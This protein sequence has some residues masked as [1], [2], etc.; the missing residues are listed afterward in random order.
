MSVD[1]QFIDLLPKHFMGVSE[2][3]AEVM[4]VISYE[5]SRLKTE[6]EGIPN[7]VDI[8]TCPP[9]YLP[10]IAY[11]L[12]VTNFPELS[13]DFEQRRFLRMYIEA[14]H[15]KG[16]IYAIQLLFRGLFDIPDIRVTEMYRHIFN[17]WYNYGNGNDSGTFWDLGDSVKQAQRAEGIQVDDRLIDDIYYPTMILIDLEA[18]A[19]SSLTNLAQLINYARSII[20]EFIPEVCNWELHLTTLTAVEVIP[21]VEIVAHIE[22]EEV[23]DAFDAN[24]FLWPL[25]I[26]GV[27]L[28]SESVLLHPDTD[29]IKFQLV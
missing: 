8:E 29:F 24:S 3:A 20:G 6:V 18:A 17:T 10:L 4:R 16:T 13:T 15:Y 12:G 2:H 1:E 21:P 11:M 14:L 7:V 23:E 19:D 9:Q 22:A 28:V 27:S 26:P 5:L 25:F